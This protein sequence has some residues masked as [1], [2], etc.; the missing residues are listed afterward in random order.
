M[1][2]V[3][4]SVIKPVTC[5]FALYEGLS[6]FFHVQFLRA[7]FLYHLR[8]IS[9]FVT[10]YRNVVDQCFFIQASLYTVRDATFQEIS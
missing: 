8:D 1:G 10:T 2:T 6:N 5:R 7:S 3:K 4:M 9:D